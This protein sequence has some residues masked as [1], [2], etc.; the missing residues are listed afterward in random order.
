[1]VATLI[2]PLTRAMTANTQNQTLTLVLGGNGKTGRR[3]AER[4]RAIGHPVRLGSRSGSPAFDWEKESTWA[5]ALA[6][7]KSVYLTFQPDA[8][9]P[10]AA[11]TIGAFAKLAAATG[12]EHIVALTGRG[13]EG[14]LESEQAIQNAGVEW[15]IVRAAFF[16]Q[17]FSEDFLVEAVQSGF[18]AFPADQVREP[19]IDAEDIADVAVAALTEPGHAGEVYEVTGPELLTFGEAVARIA[20]TSG[21]EVRYLP[22]TL[23]QFEEGMVSHGVPG[24]FAALFT[25]LF[26]EVLD[27]RNAHVTDGVYRALGR[28]PRSFADYARATAATGVWGSAQ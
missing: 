12:V 25:D 15:T 22:V 13:E 24:D 4:L 10:G 2:R 19:F 11:E 14:A 8:G 3:V 27:G 17:N 1:M 23:H 21:K 28:Q 16:S 7:V 5:P 26:R 18:V 9:F 6:G 20:A